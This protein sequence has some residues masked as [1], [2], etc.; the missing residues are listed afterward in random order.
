MDGFCPRYPRVSVLVD[1]GDEY[2]ELHG[3]EMIFGWR[4]SG[5]GPLTEEA[6]AALDEP[7]HLCGDKYSGGLFVP[8]GRHAWVRSSP[9]RS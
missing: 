9:T 7:E 6:D 3:V 5:R 2:M 4:G 1:G 8:D